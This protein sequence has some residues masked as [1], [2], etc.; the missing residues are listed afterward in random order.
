MSEIISS[1]VMYVDILVNGL[2][3]YQ[4]LKNNK[5]V[6]D[7]STTSP[8]L[9]FLWGRGITRNLTFNPRAFTSGGD[10]D[11]KFSNRKIQ[12]VVRE[13]KALD[14]NVRDDNR[15][16]MVQIGLAVVYNHAETNVVE[17]WPPPPPPLLWISI[18]GRICTTTFYTP[19]IKLTVVSTWTSKSLAMVCLGTK[20]CEL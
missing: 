10:G 1:D 4:W 16:R 6:V 11:H 3:Y 19:Q 20:V 13:C 9:R 12:R 8:K 14:I 7:P 15:L 5:L 17:G 2:G 18:L